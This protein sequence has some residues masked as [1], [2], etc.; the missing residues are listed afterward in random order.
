MVVGEQWPI[1]WSNSVMLIR[2]LGNKT[3][4]EVRGKAVSQISEHEKENIL[5]AVHSHPTM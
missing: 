2:T 5:S 1:N 3:G 4:P